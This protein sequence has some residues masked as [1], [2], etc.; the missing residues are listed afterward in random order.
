MRF[1]TRHFQ[2]FSYAAPLTLSLCQGTLFF[3]A[4]NVVYHNKSCLLLKSFLPAFISEEFV[5]FSS[6]ES[7]HFYAGL[8]CKPAL[9]LLLRSGR[10]LLLCGGGHFNYVVL[11]LAKITERFGS[12][13]ACLDPHQPN[14]KNL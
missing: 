6:F 8:H 1:Y 4:H 3:P 13:K 5:P 7:K 9:L 2:N 11:G 10:F 14:K 12:K